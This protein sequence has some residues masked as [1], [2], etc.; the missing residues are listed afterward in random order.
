MTQLKGEFAD[1]K[2]KSFHVDTRTYT[3]KTEFPRDLWKI[4]DRKMEQK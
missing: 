2:K 4:L 3:E 1:L